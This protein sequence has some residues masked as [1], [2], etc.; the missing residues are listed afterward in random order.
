MLRHWDSAFQRKNSKK[1]KKS[2]SEL[3]TTALPIGV[4]APSRRVPKIKGHVGPFQSHFS[5]FFL[6]LTTPHFLS[7]TFSPHPPIKSHS[8]TLSPPFMQ[9]LCI[10]STFLFGGFLLHQHYSL[11]S[12]TLGNQGMTST[13]LLHCWNTTI[14]YVVNVLWNF[15]EIIWSENWI[16]NCDC[17]K[18]YRYIVDDFRI[19]GYVEIWTDIVTMILLK[20][21]LGNCPK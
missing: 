5:L 18:N 4:V 6:F 13:L 21:N 7:I 3:N 11:F 2:K 14:S 8:H 19:L 10:S 20:L 12:S 15:C 16:E 1:K 17:L 9:I